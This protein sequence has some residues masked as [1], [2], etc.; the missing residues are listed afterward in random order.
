MTL[1]DLIKKVPFKSMFNHLYKEYYKHENLK[2]SEIIELTIWHG[3][4][5]KNLLDMPKKQKENYKIYVTQPVGT[6]KI[7][8]VCLFNEFKDELIPFNEL[9][10]SDVIDLEVYRALKMSNEECMAY[11]FRQI[12]KNFI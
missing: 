10:V 4:I 2:D 8:D 11:I 12:Q 6:D 3:K 1:R 9:E 7:I 5:Y